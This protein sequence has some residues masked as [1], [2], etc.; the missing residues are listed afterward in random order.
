MECDSNENVFGKMP[1]HYSQIT[2]SMLYPYY[3]I[4][5][6]HLLNDKDEYLKWLKDEDRLHKLDSA[7]SCPHFFAYGSKKLLHFHSDAWL[8]ELD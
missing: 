3:Q 7:K 8:S 5:F 4:W 6:S 2:G 1:R